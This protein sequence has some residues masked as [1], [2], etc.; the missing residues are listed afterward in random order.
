MAAP[1]SRGLGVSQ[2]DLEAS[3]LVFVSVK[4]AK[5]KRKV[6]VPLPEGSTWEAFLQ[7]VKTKLKLAAVDSIFLASSGERVTSLD[8]L[9]DIDE[10]HVVEGAAPS[11]SGAAAQQN[12]YG[13]ASAA[14][15]AAA[16]QP[17]VHRVGVADTEITAAMSNQLDKDSDMDAKYARRQT[18]LRRTLQR[19]F[20]ALFSQPSL[21]LTSKDLQ[22][23]A[24]PVDGVR[25]RIRRRRRSL[26]DPRNLL[27]VFALVSCLGM[28][29]FVYTRTAQGLP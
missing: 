7:Q 22:N 12:G 2:S 24:S 8:Q 14:A 11:S 25:R 10:L 4:D 29:V 27:V 6:A 3:R 16:A 17:A 28:M 15:G 20:P 1:A 18:T 9:Q 23:P 21:P 19:V 26:T 13:S 5:P